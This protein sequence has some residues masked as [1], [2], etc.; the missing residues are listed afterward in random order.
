MG[1]VGGIGG[2]VG[3]PHSRFGIENIGNYVL[4]AMF[5]VAWNMNANAQP[6]W[7]GVCSGVGGK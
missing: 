1:W 5:A 6:C 3:V 7:V 4:L 2:W